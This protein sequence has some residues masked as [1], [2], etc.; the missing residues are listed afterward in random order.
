MAAG[1]KTYG[2]YVVEREIGHGGMGSVHLG[3]HRLLERPAVLKKMR[4]ELSS[5][6]ELVERFRREARTAAA[7]HHPNVVAVYDCFNFRG[8]LIIAQEY[9]DG[10][11]LATALSQT[12]RVPPRIAG[13]IALEL[14]RG[15]EEVHGR[16]IVHRDLKPANILLGSAGETKIADFG[17]AFEGRGDALTRPGVMMGSPPYMPP[18]QMLGERVD[19]RGDLFAWGVVFYEMLTAVPPFQTPT[20]DDA[21]SL[22]KRI[23]RG[24]YRGVRKLAPA[25]PRWMARLIHRCLRAQPRKRIQGATLLRTVLERR[26]GDP[27]PA[28][29]REELARWLWD[30]SVIEADS[31][32]TLRAP[33]TPPSP[34]HP[35]R[36]W[37]SATA[38]GAVAAAAF[39]ALGVD[40]VAV[41]P[42]I[43]AEAPAE[44]PAR[45][46]DPDPEEAAPETKPR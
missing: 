19:Y 38:A 42:A 21:D 10:V 4:R 1:E 3:Q 24:R 11:D 43:E 9:V 31:N 34:R 46:P 33:A 13:L 45:A 5:N 15:L 28:S 37:L 12:R 30:R 29:C 44:K 17:I 20:E 26:L 8:D 7:I 40:V 22:L 6:D 39:L 25:T 41:L 23:Q 16:G 14:L 35:P 2:S 18:E 32:C 27:P 36:P